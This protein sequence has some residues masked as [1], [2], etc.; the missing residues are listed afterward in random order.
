MSEPNTSAPQAS[1]HALNWRELQEEGLQALYVASAVL[2]VGFVYLAYSLPFAWPLA[3]LG[4]GFI[5]LLYPLHRVFAQRYLVRAWALAALWTAAALAVSAQFPDT[6]APSLLALP[7]ALAGLL[8]SRGAGILVAAGLS[9]ALAVLARLNPGTSAVAWAMPLAMAWGTALLVWIALRPLEEAMRWS[10]AAYDAARRELELARDA[11]ADLKQAIKDLAE[12]NLQTARLN[13]LLGM[14][15]RAAEEAERAKAEFVANVSHELRTPL[16]MIIGFSEMIMAAPRTYG[17]VSTALRADLAVIHRNSQHL[18]S[19]ID[20]VLDLSQIEAGRMALTKEPVRLGEIVE[21]AAEAIR[22][23]YQTKGLHLR[24]HVP[25]SLVVFCDRTRMREVL[26]NLLS[27]AGRFTEQGGVTVLVRVV[28]DE[29]VVSVSDTGPGIAPEDQARLFQPFQQAD[30]SIRRRFGGTGLGLSISKH[31]VELHDGRMWLESP[32]ED[33]T[34]AAPPGEI[35]GAVEEGAVGPGTAIFFSLPFEPS[36]AGGATYSRWLNADWEYRQRTRKWLAPKPV[37]RS[38]VIVVEHGTLLQ[39]LVRRYLADTDLIA[40]G[41]LAEAGE[42]LARGPASALLVHDSAIGEAIERIRESNLLPAGTLALVCALPEQE[43]A[44]RAIGADD[45]LVK[46]VSG[47]ALLAALDRFGIASG[48]ILIVDDEQDAIQLFWRM[49]AACGRGYRVLTAANGAQALAVLATDRPDAIL[50][51]LTMP[52]VDG[53][54]LL[55][56]R[57]DEPAWRDV[58]VIIMSARDPAGHPIVAS[59]FGITRGGG[60]TVP[61]LL[62]HIE[63]AGLGRTSVGAKHSDGESPSSTFA[64]AERPQT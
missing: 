16:N 8:I 19:L 44:A 36:P 5:L 43:E 4:I 60:L 40:V 34:P 29:V 27:N 62:A 52:G 37:V 15:R 50:L 17:R 18:S 9:F 11:Q 49:L 6:V 26:L 33:Q 64:A 28:D 2:G 24:T 12:A 46:P 56:L 14:A 42:E 7:V 54:Q 41:S 31:F 55:A 51:D 38:R 61:Q 21:A 58:P 10:W 23:L 20:D 35:V 63:A 57:K 3:M 48:T 30:G 47:S 22:P 13:Q 25:E 59:A 45:Y 32:A 53:F 1:S 39:R